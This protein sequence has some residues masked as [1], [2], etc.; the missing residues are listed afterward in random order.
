MKKETEMEVYL[1]Y[2]SRYIGTENILL[3]LLS[4]INTFSNS[5]LGFVNKTAHYYRIYGGSKMQIALQPTGYNKQ[6]K[7]LFW[8]N[9]N[10]ERDEHIKT[11]CGNSASLSHH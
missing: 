3:L 1:T 5:I 11:E 2:S 4:T 7:F 6:D 8:K 10:L 9:E